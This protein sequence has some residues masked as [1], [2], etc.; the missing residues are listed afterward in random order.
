LF[1]YKTGICEKDEMKGVASVCPKDAPYWN[2]LKL[3]CEACK[4][5]ESYNEKLKACAAVRT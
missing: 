3:V 5:G 4:A 2:N 1:N